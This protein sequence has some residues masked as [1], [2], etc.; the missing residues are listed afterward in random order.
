MVFSRKSSVFADCV[1]LGLAKIAFL[2]SNVII[3][4]LTNRGSRSSIGRAVHKSAKC[5]FSTT[6]TSCLRDDPFIVI[7][8]TFPVATV[9]SSKLLFSQLGQG[10]TISETTETLA[11]KS[12]PTYYQF[13]IVTRNDVILKACAFEC[14]LWSRCLGG[15]HL[16]SFSIDS[17]CNLQWRI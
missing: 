14:S 11:V 1:P 5:F 7:F 15:N 9:Q 4:S 10:K 16:V 6:W 13:T 17:I 2:V 3:F 12:V 8:A